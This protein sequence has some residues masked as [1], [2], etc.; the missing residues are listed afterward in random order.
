MDVQ[1]GRHSCVDL[2]EEL[3]ELDGAVALVALSDHLAGLY[4]KGGEE[5]GRAM[6]DIVVRTALDLARPGTTSL[7][8]RPS[9]SDRLW[10]RQNSAL[11]AE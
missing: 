4:V 7:S 5:R 10:F 9:S 3:A 2:V 8:V 1:I 11:G 6:P